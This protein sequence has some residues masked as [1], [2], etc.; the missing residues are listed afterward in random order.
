MRLRVAASFLALPVAGLFGACTSDLDAPDAYT[1]PSVSAGNDTAGDLGLD[2]DTFPQG[3][4]G[5]D[6]DFTPEVGGMDDGTRTWLAETL[7]EGLTIDAGTGQITGVPTTA[8]TTSVDFTV[9]DSTGMA[10][11][12]CDIVIND[13]LGVDIDLLVDDVPGC[14]R[15]GD[16][17]LLD[18]VVDGTGDGTPITCDHPGGRGNGSRPAGIS[19]NPD[20]C[21]IEGTVMENR[22]GTWVFMVRGTQSGS[23]VWVP[24]CVS[25]DDNSGYDVS[26][27]HSML[28][29]DGIDG[30]LVPMLRRFNPGASLALGET[31]DPLFSILSPGDCGANNCFFGFAFSIDTSSPFEVFRVVESSIVTDNGPQGFTHGIEL[32]GPEPGDE[33]A[34]RPFAFR[35]DLDYCLSDTETDCSCTDAEEN[36][37]G[38]D[39]S[40]PEADEGPRRVRA[41]GDGNIA[42]SVLMVPE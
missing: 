17:T 12:T 11:T 4:V 38:S 40:D 22:D 29:D 8:G 7:P 30:T 28:S 34:G 42:F 26:V 9:M 35:V 39:C 21:E 41:N 20:T 25:D 6:Y 32:E 13:G 5:A 1:E 14:L 19:V 27:D 16:Q 10:A 37:P 2:C 31:G 24:Y 36:D 23:E 33:F 18:F 3:A 15:P